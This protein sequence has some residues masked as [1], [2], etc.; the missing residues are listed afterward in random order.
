[1]QR[2]VGRRARPT[3][4]PIIDN[5]ASAG[6]AARWHTPSAAALQPRLLAATRTTLHAAVGSL[7]LGGA[8]RIVLDWAA[9]TA[10]QHTV[11]L[12]VVRSSAVT[13]KVP[14][15]IELVQLGNEQPVPDALVAQGLAIAASGH[16]RVLCHLLTA[17]ERE[18]LARG[19]A[20]PIPVVHN[21]QAGWIEDGS[22]YAREPEVIVVSAA[23]AAELRSIG[24]RPVVLRHYPT[25]PRPV[26]DARSAWRMRWD[27]PASALC[28]GM[29]GGVKPQKA[30]PRALRILAALR[31]RCDAH[32]VIVG[33]PVGRD[34]HLAWR[35][36]LD[37]TRRL[38]LERHVRLPGFVTEAART[39]P[40]FDML[41]NTSRYEG[42]SI[43]TMEA[44]AAGL[45]VVAA[46]V[47]GQREIAQPGLTLI[48]FDAPVSEWCNA[49]EAV[50][51]QPVT[52]PPW[53]GFPSARLW[54]L[55]HIDLPV[56]TGNRALFV[57]AN[58]NAGGAQRSLLNLART[59]HAS[60]P[61]SIAVCGVSSSGEFLRQ[62][63]DAGIDVFR[64]AENRDCFDHAEAI[65]LRL[66]DGDIGT[67]VF[68]NVDPKV[69]L[70]LAKRLALPSI[71]LID[72]SPGHYAFEE[73]DATADFQRC[74]ALGSDAYHARLD[75]LVL[76]YRT[77]DTSGAR[78]AY[79]PNG[80]PLPA[81]QRGPIESARNVVV[82]GRIAPSKFLVEIITA[83]RLVWRSDPDVRLHLLG[84]V[85]ARH[86]E[87]G[88]TVFETIGDELAR[89]VIVHGA[90]SD[91]PERLA[92]FDVALVIGHHQ[93]SPNAVLEAMAAGLAVVAN[94][95]G[96]TRE[97]VLDGR[98]GILL[99]DR[100]P[101][102][103]AKSLLRLMQN[104]RLASR[105]ARAGR[106]H[107][108]K[109]FS[110]ARMAKAYRRLLTE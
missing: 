41:L 21:A 71:R 58:L 4:I 53:L 8:E 73:M 33:G 94:D 109:Q 97:L 39:L 38:N 37:Q 15:N 90:A 43:A 61:L 1:M 101:P 85:E 16:P 2:F 49:I 88:D 18:A 52:A 104:T 27:L 105:L 66:R 87:Y 35:A 9:V 28:I 14:E 95:S 42:V 46:D 60:L 6:R 77:R 68:W 17:S 59:L 91:A 3:R 78:T 54:T 79:V 50:Q 67:L 19:G 110:M 10:R 36:V 34:G 44:L 47:G 81:R 22:R 48:P 63:T 80:V 82:S 99:P 40:A 103:I 70:L 25:R 24:A 62:L 106:A 75:R 30:Y 100:A 26:S 76:K 20:Q 11:R 45:P 31:E 89:R 107:V 13:W 55:H 102:T 65:L 69:K 84:S 12:I 7:A 86:R 51:R 108:E 29:V 23:A 32:L 92:A 93:G 56:R 98:T 83:M 72:V 5:A 74:I 57:T 96:G 64:T